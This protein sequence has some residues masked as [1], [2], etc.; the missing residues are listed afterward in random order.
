MTEKLRFNTGKVKIF[1][2]SVEIQTGFGH[3]LPSY[4]MGSGV[5]TPELKTTGLEADHSSC[6]VQW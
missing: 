3:H 5:F 6:L 4:W 1:F 2:S